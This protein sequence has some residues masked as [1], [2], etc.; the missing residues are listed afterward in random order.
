MSDKSTGWLGPLADRLLGWG[1]R[2]DHRNGSG[3]W[4]VGF[5]MHFGICSNISAELQARSFGIFL[6][7]EEGFRDILCELDAKVCLDLTRAADIR[8][9]PLGSVIADIRELLQ[10]NW[11]CNILPERAILQRGQK[12]LFLA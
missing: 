3:Q 11:R 6:A 1:W 2:F 5:K 12:S 4:L 8:V 7:W 10:R 9:H